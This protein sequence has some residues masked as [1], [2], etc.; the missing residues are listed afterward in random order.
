[1]TIK[2]SVT[3]VT[4]G[5]AGKREAAIAAMI[6]DNRLSQPSTAVAVILEGIPDGADP[7]AVHF[8]NFLCLNITRIAPGCPCCTG[9]LTMRVTLNR[10]LRQKPENLYISLSTL[11]HPDQIRGFFS[12][13][14]Y[15]K[16]IELTKELS[17]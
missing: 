2:T 4:G 3:L 11:T 15:N 9:N 8:G 12:Q 6:A 7:F 13:P 14:P 16:L 10:V 17:I 5:T 1:M